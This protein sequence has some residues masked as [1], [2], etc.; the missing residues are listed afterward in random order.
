MDNL[1]H[2]TV[3]IF[4]KEGKSQIPTPNPKQF[5]ISNAQKGTSRVV[6]RL[7][8]VLSIVICLGFGNWDL[9]LPA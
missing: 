1:A 9:E 4:G 7:F 8:G 2:K 6:S 5:L 3:M